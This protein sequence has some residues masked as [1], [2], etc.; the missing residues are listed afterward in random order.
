MQQAADCL[1]RDYYVSPAAEG[2][3]KIQKTPAFMSVIKK[4][5]H[6]FDKSSQSR[7]STPSKYQTIENIDVVS[8]DVQ[9][10][11]EKQFNEQISLEQERIKEIQEQERIKEIQE[12]ERIKEIQEQERKAIEI[13]RLKQVHELNKNETYLEYLH[14]AERFRKDYG[15]NIRCDICGEWEID[16]FQ[17]RGQTYCKMH[18]PISLDTENEYKVTTGRHGSSRSFIKK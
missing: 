12:Q 9:I 16:L 2:Q 5:K 8:L 17:H 7:G 13:E 10:A 3:T 14:E 18:I 4:I 1:G 15:K 11:A 6:Y